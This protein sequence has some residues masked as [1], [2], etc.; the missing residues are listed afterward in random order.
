MNTD[1]QFTNHGSIVTVTPLTKRAK[2]FITESVSYEPWQCLGKAIALDH[3]Y[4]RDLADVMIR[5]G[6]SVR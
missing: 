1:F 5:V 6:L 2:K 3:R 4:A